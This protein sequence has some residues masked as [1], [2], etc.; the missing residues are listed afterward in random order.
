M[1]AGN[2]KKESLREQV[3]SQEVFASE[4]H[5]KY[6]TEVDK[7]LKKHSRALK[8]EKWITGPMWFFIVI[9][10]MAFLTIGGSSPD[11]AKKLWFGILAC[12]WLIF[13]AVF[14]LRYF[15]NRN[16]LETL[17]ELK[18]IQLRMEEFKEQITARQENSATPM[19][20]DKE[21]T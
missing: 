16:R 15:I 2:N 7:R 17:K 12:F 9:V 13:G 20:S 5:E 19:K 8:I 11:P 6:Q 1:P 4:R 18:E 10:C 3:L 14:L 21:E